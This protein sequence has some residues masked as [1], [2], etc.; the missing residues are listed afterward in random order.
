MAVRSAPAHGEEAVDVF[1]PFRDT[2]FGSVSNGS[3]VW[4]HAHVPEEE[5]DSE[6]G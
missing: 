5:R 6:V 2:A 1:S 4:E 3:E